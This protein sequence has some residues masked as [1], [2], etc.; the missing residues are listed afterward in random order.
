M[1]YDRL[2]TAITEIANTNAVISIGQENGF[3]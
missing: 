3:I 1:R 2:I